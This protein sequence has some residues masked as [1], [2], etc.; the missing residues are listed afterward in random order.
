MAPFVNVIMK[1]CVHSSLRLQC[2]NCSPSWFTPV[3]H[4]VDTTMLTS[5]KHFFCI[6]IYIYSIKAALGCFVVET[7][8]L[9]Y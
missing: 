4:P 8:L 3:E 1:F 6:Y 2:T 9:L 7:F 5:S